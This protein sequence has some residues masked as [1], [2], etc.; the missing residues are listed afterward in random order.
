L[1]GDKRHKIAAYGAHAIRPLQRNILRFAGVAPV[2]RSLIGLV[3]DKNAGRRTRRLA[4][5]ERLGAKGA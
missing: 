4:A 3:E 1:P 2:R 5:L